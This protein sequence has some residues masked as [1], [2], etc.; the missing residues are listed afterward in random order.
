MSIKKRASVHLSQEVLDDLEA[1]AAAQG[2][3]VGAFLTQL[4][5]EIWR[6][7][8]FGALRRRVKAKQLQGEDNAHDE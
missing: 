4:V 8:S 6:S 5:N 3:P 7:P 1:V 2:D